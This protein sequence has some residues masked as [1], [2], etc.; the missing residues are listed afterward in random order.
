MLSDDFAA[1][2]GK[3]SDSCG[4]KL[5]NCVRLFAIPWTVASRSEYWGGLPFPSIADLPD[6]E[7]EPR[8]PAL[9][10]DVLPSEPPGRNFDIWAKLSPI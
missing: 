4:M 6:P 1:R 10:A 5:C 7:I 2:R 9:Q 3:Q 8:S